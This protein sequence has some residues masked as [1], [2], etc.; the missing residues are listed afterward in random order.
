MFSTFFSLADGFI[1]PSRRV[2]DPVVEITEIIVQV[3]HA[4]VAGPERRAVVLPHHAGL[5]RQ[6]LFPRAVGRVIF[7]FLS[8]LFLFIV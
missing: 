1:S 2:V 3:P 7:V 8:S 5:P 6:S 4:R